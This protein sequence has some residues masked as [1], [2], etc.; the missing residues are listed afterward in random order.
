[1]D[2]SAFDVKGK[3]FVL[4]GKFKGIDKKSAA[5]ALKARGAKVTSSL[6][7]R[8]HVLVASRYFCSKSPAKRAKAAELGITLWSETEIAALM[9]A[10]GV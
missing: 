3:S 5:A 8:T 4:T 9:Q 10:E 1:M 7:G 6:S 2:L